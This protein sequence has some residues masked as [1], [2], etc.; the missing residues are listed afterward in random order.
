MPKFIVQFQGQESVAELKPGANSVGRQ[1]SN[2]IP[3]KDSTL[4]RLHCEVILAG[5][6]A[7][8]VDKGSRNGTLLNGKKIDAQVLQPGDKIQIGATTLWYEKKNVA[9]EKPALPKATPTDPALAA[10]PQAARPAPAPS[11]RRSTADAKPATVGV[12]PQAAISQIPD[13]SFHGKAGG[14]AGK[15]VAAVLV[16]ALLGVG[17]YFLRAW[18]DKPVVVDVDEGNLVSKNAHFDGQKP[19][20]WGMRPSLT[21]DK[22]SATASIDQS[23]GRNGGPCLVLD[24]VAGAADL[25]AEC[26]FQ[27]DLTLPKGMAV[28]VSAFSQFEGFN[29]WAAVK[30]DWLKSARG[31]VIAQDFSDPV[32]APAWTEIKATFNPPANAGAFRVALAIVGR[33]GRVYFDDVNVKT[34]A[35]APAPAEKKIGKYHKVAWTRAGLL[36]L[37]LR[38]GRRTLTNLSAR[39]DSDKEGSTPQAFSTDVSVTP[40]EGGVSF[41][42]RMVTPI[43]LREIPFEERIGEADGL[44]TIEYTFPGEVLKQVDRVTIAL[45]LPRV[46]GPPG[47]IP[48]NGDP[49]SRIHCTAEEGEFAIEY[50]DPARV[51]FRTIDGRIR[52]YQT[53]TVDPSV[54]TFT[55]RIRE[56]GGG[57]NEVFNPVE[58][59]AKLRG[60]AK[61]GEALSIARDAVKKIREVPVKERMQ[62][63]IR[64]LEEQ[65]R[66]DWVEAQAL[67]FQASISR[68]PEIAAKAVQFLTGYLRQWAGEGSEGKADRL[69]KKLNDELRS[70]P[71]SEAERPKRLVDRAKKLLDGGK[72]AIAQMIL[73]TVVSRYPASEVVP[74]AQQLLKSL[75]E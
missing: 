16:V 41:K 21:G 13:Y 58:E 37:E 64:G 51:K 12:R 32:K 54:D 27:D 56:A 9:A 60:Q 2:N 29:G 44:T 59:I 52:I 31:S 35:G 42:G 15:I 25:V 33:G 74:E 17:G 6:V 23:H 69:L 8:L 65:E 4:S 72:R 19:D 38:G 39:L 67:A 18:L 45:T 26:G 43:D 49:T 47:G 1:S 57:P 36:Q 40:D 30:I 7:T 66:R 24:K 71:A 34:L 68:R 61:L 55:F 75:S 46:D 50:S 5:T 22:S 14:N 62:D 70:T 73:Q 48:E 3:L 11:T 63:E 10:Q 28:A 53:W 20:G